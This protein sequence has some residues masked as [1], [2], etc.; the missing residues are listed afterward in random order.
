MSQVLAE[1]FIHKVFLPIRV[2]LQVYA[3]RDDLDF[4]A[5]ADV[6]AVQEWEL[7]ENFDGQI[8]YPTQ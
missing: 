6:P 7:L 3:N 1:M 2:H 8:E 5:V 4:S